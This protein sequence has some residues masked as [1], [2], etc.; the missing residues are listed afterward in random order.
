R[1]FACGLIALALLAFALRV[2]AVVAVGSYRLEHVTY[3]HG[4][5][6][7]NLVEGRGFSVRW[8]GAEGP[9]SQQA[10]VYPTLLAAFYVIFGVQTPAALLSMQIFQ[11]LLG[12]LLSIGVVL[13][14]KELIPLL[15]LATWMAG[16]GVAL[17]PTLIYGVTQVQVATVV[18]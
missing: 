2:V 1:N 4:E 10:P 7:T 14:A 13:L 3:E 16:F 17:Y 12:A 15:R 8:L 9:T 5:I 11:A 18:S 6:A